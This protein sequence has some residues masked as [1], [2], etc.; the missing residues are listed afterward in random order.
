MSGVGPRWRVVRDP[1]GLVG[2]VRGVCVFCGKRPLGSRVVHSGDDWAHWAC[3]VAARIDAENRRR[4]NAG[5]TFAG[6]PAPYRRKV[7]RD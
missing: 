1:A 4:I 6:T 2:L 5:E 3:A 7:Q